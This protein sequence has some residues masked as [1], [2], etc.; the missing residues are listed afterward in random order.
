M[1]HL[2]VQGKGSVYAEPDIVLISFTVSG[3]AMDY[4]AALKNLNNRVNNLRDNLS[5]S[6]LDKSDLKTTD[7]NVSVETEYK[8]ERR[9][10]AGYR[11]THRLIIE[12]TLEKELLNSVLANIGEGYSGA[13][14]NLQ[15]S[16]KDRESLKEQVLIQAVKNAR[17]NAGILASAAGV[18]LGEIREIN[19]HWSEIHFF[20]RQAEMVCE[21][22]AEY[23]V[24]IEPEEISVS[25][26]V[27]IIYEI[28]D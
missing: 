14:I 21:S 5:V 28:V 10:F 27:T 8:N 25:D 1:K 17:K 6:G 18:K 23:N 15:F 24:D 13:Q 2:N 12:L 7:F 3:K 11:A 26:N 19:Y 20:Q 16:V 22:A 9:V 4:E